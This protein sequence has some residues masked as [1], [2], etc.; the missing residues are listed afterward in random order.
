VPARACRDACSTAGL[1]EG[2]TRTALS[3]AVE[4]VE[5][6]E[7]EHVNWAKHTWQRMTMMQVKSTVVMKI[8]DFA[9]KTLATVKNAVTG[10]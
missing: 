4:E 8:T 5:A 2:P 7:D 1:P 3:A 6:N 9:E 10:A